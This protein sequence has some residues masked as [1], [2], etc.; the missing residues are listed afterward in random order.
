[1][2]IVVHAQLTQ[3]GPR[4]NGAAGV[5]VVMK[6]NKSVFSFLRRAVA[7]LLLSAGPPVVQQSIDG[8][9]ERTDRRRYRRTDRQT[10]GG[11]GIDPALHTMQA[12]PI[13]LRE[14][15]VRFRLVRN[16]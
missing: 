9:D 2:I 4:T 16:H 6:K 8:T 15:G 14:V 5:A 12:M 7:Q 11:T 13:I 10:D 3:V 1:M